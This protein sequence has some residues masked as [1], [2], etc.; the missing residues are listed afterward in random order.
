MPGIL[1]FLFKE[2]V[3]LDT[4][5]TDTIKKYRPAYFKIFDTSLTGDPEC[6]DKISLQDINE[7]LDQCNV[8]FGWQ[9]TQVAR[10][11]YN[12]FYADKDAY[13]KAKCLDPAQISDYYCI[14]DLGKTIKIN[15]WLWYTIAREH[16]NL[17]YI[18]RFKFNV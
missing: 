10:D 5:D 4:F 8:D 3:D 12:N 7:F 13:I 6:F 15:P 18:D 1:T 2:G 9:P 16:N 14:L 17:D 11:F